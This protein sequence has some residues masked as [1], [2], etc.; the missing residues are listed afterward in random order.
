MADTDVIVAAMRSPGGASAAILRA[1]RRERVDLLLSVPLAM[2]YEA[3]C[4]RPEHQIAAG[5]SEQ[6]VHVFVDTVIAMAEPVKIYFLWRPQLRDPSD[7]MVLETAVNGQADLLV[8]FNARNY[9]TVPERFGIQV[10]TPR[11]AMERI[12]R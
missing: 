12:G 4:L 11:Q 5:L 9:G 7:E 10:M 1:V 2:E 8:T 3:V 6:E